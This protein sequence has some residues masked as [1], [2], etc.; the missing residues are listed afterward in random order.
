[1]SPALHLA[2]GSSNPLQS[3]FVVE[4]ESRLPRSPRRGLSS[5]FGT[6]D[7][8]TDSV[9]P[10]CF[11]GIEDLR[12]KREEINRQLSSDEQ[13]K[14]K[15]QNDLAILTR[16]LAHLNEKLSRQIASRNEYDRTIQETEAAYSKILESSQTLLTVLKR[17]TVNI[18]KK[19]Q[20]SS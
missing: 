6:R 4:P 1:M 17:E 13:E 14:A 3:V 20:S 18:A 12:E 10:P 9:P 8:P 19:R 11:P 15:I 2:R 16:R 7:R 5:Q